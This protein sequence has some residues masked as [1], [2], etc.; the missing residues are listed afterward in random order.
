MASYFCKFSGCMPGSG[1]AC[2]EGRPPVSSSG[3]RPSSK[4]A[5]MPAPKFRGL[6]V[7]PLLME[8][9]GGHLRRP[10]VLDSDSQD[11][12]LQPSGPQFIESG[13][14]RPLWRRQLHKS[15]GL[16]SSVAEGADW[17]IHP[18]INYFQPMETEI[19]QRG[20][21][22]YDSGEESDDEQ[23]S[24][25]A[26]VR[27]RRRSRQNVPERNSSGMPQLPRHSLRRVPNLSSG[28][29][30]GSFT[31][32]QK[33]PASLQKMPACTFDPANYKESNKD[34]FLGQVNKDLVALAS[35]FL[36]C[37]SSDRVADEIESPV[38][39]QYGRVYEENEFKSLLAINAEDKETGQQLVKTRQVFLG[40]LLEILS[41][42]RQAELFR[43][44][45]SAANK[46]PGGKRS[47]KNETVDLTFLKAICTIQ[48]P[49]SMSPLYEMD[50]LVLDAEGHFFDGT[51][52]RKALARFKKNPLS[53][54]FMQTSDIRT[55]PWVS[56]LCKRLIAVHGVCPLRFLA[57]SHEG[58]DGSPPRKKR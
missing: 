36:C 2:F 48:S 42:A 28:S 34:A 31:G 50:D 43:E 37:P 11:E 8:H 55:I 58:E 47:K 25:Q 46:K 54:E 3:E 53:N 33:V 24:Q 27:S 52:L 32:A 5:G 14:P 9:N 6:P 15:R 4:P 1:R 38:Y 18:F 29:L 57:D 16:S 22:T 44:I 7:S 45:P 17:A 13:S 39:D 56:E 41:K 12:E 30:L 26:L 51:S 20:G 35:H 10:V 19:A 21:V 23:E 40:D 49:I